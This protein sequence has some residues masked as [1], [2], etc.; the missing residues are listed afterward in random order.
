MEASAEEEDPI[1]GVG[2]DVAGA[3][4]GAESSDKT[5]EEDLVV[6]A[7]EEDLVVVDVCYN[8]PPPQS[9]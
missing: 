9:L 2:I 1:V 4:G 3:S 7:D 5:E 6:V 8:R